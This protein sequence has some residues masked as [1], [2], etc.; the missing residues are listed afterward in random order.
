VDEPPESRTGAEQLPRRHRLWGLDPQAVE[1]W[2]DGVW[3]AHLQELAALRAQVAESDQ[4]RAADAEAL[5]V[6][7]R[8]GE[9]N[10]AALQAARQQ[11]AE[12]ETGLREAQQ[13]AETLQQAVE[14]LEAR[15]HDLEQRQQIMREEAMATVA[16]AWTKAQ[17]I[18]EQ[19]Q[20]LLQQTRAQ[21]QQE[22]Q[23][24]HRQREQELGH[25]RA[26]IDALRGEQTQAIADVETLAHRLLDFAASMKGETL[27]LGEGTSAGLPDSA[28]AAAVQPGGVATDSSAGTAVP[29]VNKRAETAAAPA[30]AT[31][32]DLEQLLEPPR[33]QQE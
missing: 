23:D 30:L 13:R 16:A 26:S 32:P 15:G 33:H 1:T 25:W 10:T 28:Q 22:V 17:G 8:R 9:E 11:L 21:A 18:E 19:A 6:A 29:P 14:D 2:A 5:R 7:R 27:P 12:Q 31:D 20:R 3:K 24:L 4:Q